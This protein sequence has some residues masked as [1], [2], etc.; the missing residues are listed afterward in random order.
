MKI[1]LTRQ[2]PRPRSRLL[3]LDTR[4][5]VIKIP[6]SPVHGPDEPITMVALECWK[7][8]ASNVSQDSDG[9]LIVPPRSALGVIEHG[10]DGTCLYI[11]QLHRAGF[12]VVTVH[13]SAQSILSRSNLQYAE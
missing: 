9:Q 3:N 8:V 4:H 11:L 10:D 5:C 12:I 2:P 7:L 13:I 6:V 1:E